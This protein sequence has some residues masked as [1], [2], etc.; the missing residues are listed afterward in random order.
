MAVRSYAAPITAEPNRSAVVP[1]VATTASVHAYATVE[2]HVQLGDGTYV[3][4]AAS[5]RADAGAPFW[6]GASTVIQDGVVIAGLPQGRV[7]GDDQQPYSVW[8]GGNVVISHLSLVKGP[9]Y[10]G[11]DCFIGFR[12]TIFN[13]RLGKGCVVMMHALVQDVEIPPGKFIPSGSI[14]TQQQ[15]ADRLPNVEEKDRNFVRHLSGS[16]FSRSAQPSASFAPSGDLSIMN[17]PPAHTSNVA[18]RSQAPASGITAA[19][20]E[21]IRKLLNQGYQIGTEHADARRFRASAWQTCSPIKANREPEVVAALQTCLVEHS[22]E[23]VRLIG[24]DTKSKRRVSEAIIQRPGDNPA[25]HPPASNYNSASYSNASYSAPSYSAPANSHTQAGSGAHGGDWSAQ[26]QQLLNQGLQVGLEYA[27]ARRYKTS[28][29]QSGGLLSGGQGQVLNEINGFVSAHSR[30]YVRLI[31]ID[32]RAK[33]RV[34]EI[35]IYRPGASNGNGG[36]ASSHASSHASTYTPSNTANSSSSYSPSYSA[37]AAPASASGDASAQVRQ[38]LTQGLK[39]GLEYADERH[40]KTSS[41]TSLGQHLSHEGEVLGAIDRLIADNPKLYVRL[42]GIDPKAKKRVVETTI[43]RPNG[44]G[45]AKPAASRQPARGFAPSSGGGGGASRTAG[46]AGGISAEA[47]DQVR[48]LL[49]QGCQV[50]IEHA[51]PRRYRTSSWTSATVIRSGQESEAIA[52][53]EATL[54]DFGNDYVRLVGIDP[55]AKRRVA[56][57]VIHQPQK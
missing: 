6:I 43:Y 50:G 57:L 37:N 25:A 4:P 26:A 12:S 45:G 29:W 10:I 42:I 22:G 32:P 40:Y 55:K 2:G 27:D 39:V 5:I 13:A 20:I 9:A 36:S 8:V 28:S 23:Y 48:Q 47:R 14:I 53:L 15:Q 16:A 44:Q 52:A 24:I 30:D 38:I 54:H 33:K 17:K 51:D 34:A 31:G 46:H 18:S 7:I 1:N 49:R 35:T 19:L 21:Q 11:D 3:A 41:W 56:E